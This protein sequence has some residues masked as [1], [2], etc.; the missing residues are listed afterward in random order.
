MSVVDTTAG[1]SIRVDEDHE[2]FSMIS[3]FASVVPG[4]VC[5][6]F[7]SRATSTGRRM[8]LLRTFA[9]RIEV[10][11]SLAGLANHHL[12]T[13]H[14][15]EGLRPQHDLAAHAFLVPHFSQARPAKLR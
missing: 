4:L 13:A 12:S 2:Y 10:Q 5:I 6:R 9:C 1:A 7:R 3:I 14:F 8:G 11:N 15:V